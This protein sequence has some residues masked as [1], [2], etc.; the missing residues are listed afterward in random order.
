LRIAC[1]IAGAGTIP[2][3]MRLLALRAAALDVERAPAPKKRPPNAFERR[4]PR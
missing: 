3:R 4:R 1:A 2:I